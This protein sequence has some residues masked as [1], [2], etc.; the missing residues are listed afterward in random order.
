MLKEKY[1]QWCLSHQICRISTIG[2]TYK[3]G[4]NTKKKKIMNM[5]FKL[6]AKINEMPPHISTHLQLARVNVQTKKL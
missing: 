4:G 3:L 5:V 6:N 2:Y 1:K